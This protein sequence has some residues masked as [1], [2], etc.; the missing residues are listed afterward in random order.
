MHIFDILLRGEGG[1]YQISCIRKLTR[2]GVRGINWG[3]C[4]EVC[5]GEE[6]VL[7]G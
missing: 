7:R 3:K 2:G 4:Q 5:V 1:R 6:L